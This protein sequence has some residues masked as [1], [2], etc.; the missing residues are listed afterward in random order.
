MTDLK[1]PE[2]H[3]PLIKRKGST[4]GIQGVDPLTAHILQRTGTETPV[5][6]ATAVGGDGNGL[7]TG[8]RSSELQPKRGGGDNTIPLVPTKEKKL[9]T[10]DLATYSLDAES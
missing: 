7:G 5:N 9:V 6:G 10:F 2:F 3:P 1:N 4:A 8:S